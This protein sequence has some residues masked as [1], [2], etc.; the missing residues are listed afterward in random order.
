MREQRRAR[1]IERAFGGQ[2]AEV[3][4]FDLARGI[5]EVGDQAKG[6]HA[7]Q[8]LEESVLAHRVVDH[9]HARAAGDLFDAGDKV[10][11]GVIDGE[12]SAVFFGQRAL[13]V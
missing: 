6:L 10:F 9:L 2:Q 3:Q 4:R 8:G 13:G 7:V 1:H 11:F 5:A 12:G